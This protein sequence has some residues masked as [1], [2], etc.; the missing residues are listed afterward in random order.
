MGARKFAQHILPRIA[1]KNPAL[2]INVTRVKGDKKN[3]GV[4]A[5]MFIE[6]ATSEPLDIRNMH[7]DKIFERL[8][9]VTGAESPETSSVI[10]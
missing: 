7:S 5:T 1:Y 4:E 8:Q 6:G 3:T 2:K 9:E 10:A